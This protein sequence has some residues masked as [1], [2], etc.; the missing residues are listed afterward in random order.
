MLVIKGKIK[1]IL[2]KSKRSPGRHC[3][4]GDELGRR[5]Q[6]EIY[7]SWFL[8]SPLWLESQPAAV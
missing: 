5:L 6:A 2:K 8:I 1:Q 7:F 3:S 4:A